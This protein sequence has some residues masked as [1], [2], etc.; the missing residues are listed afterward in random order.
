MQH[1]WKHPAESARSDNGSWP[2]VQS[3]RAS[4]ALSCVPAWFSL[5]YFL[6]ARTQLHALGDIP[7][8]AAVPCCQEFFVRF[9]LHL[10]FSL[11][12]IHIDILSPVHSHNRHIWPFH[13]LTT[14]IIWLF[15]CSA[16]LLFIFVNIFCIMRCSGV[17]IVSSMCSRES[18][19]QRKVIPSLLQATPHTQ[20]KGS[21][22]VTGWLKSL[23]LDTYGHKMGEQRE[24]WWASALGRNFQVLLFT[25]A[26]F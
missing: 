3:K 16:L 20:K 10:L 6:A 14:L 1:G 8:P 22:K 5:I 12:R 13:S 26:S 24:L 2:L 11:C 18:S 17:K 19:T 15:C 7:Q 25:V 23:S 4:W 21:G 9:G